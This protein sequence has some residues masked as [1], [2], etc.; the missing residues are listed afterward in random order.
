MHYPCYFGAQY[1]R[2]LTVFTL[3]A[4]TSES[5][6]LR[7][8]TDGSADE[9]NTPPVCHEMQCG[10]DGVFSVMV[11]GDLHGTYYD[12]LLTDRAGFTT[13]SADPWAVAAG[14]NGRRS[15][16]VDL[17][18]TDPAGWEKDHRIGTKGMNPVIWETHVRDFSL[19]AHSGVRPEWRGKYL[20]FTE[21]NT[22]VDSAG[23]HPTCV[24]YLKQLGVTHVQLQPVADY[25]TVDEATGIGYNWGYDIYNYNV[26]EG[27]YSTDPF[28]GEVRIR[29][30]KQLVQALHEEGIGVILDVVYNHTFLR[31]SWLDLTAHGEYYRHDHNGEF[32]NASGCGNET[33]SE[34]EPFRNYMI[35]SVLHWAREYHVDGFRFDLM[36]IHDVQTMNYIRE[37]L[38]KL[39]GGN[40]ILMYG[41]PW[42]CF[43]PAINEP[44][45][46][47]DKGGVKYLDTRIGIFSDATRNA[48]GG[49]TF[50]IKDS[51]YACGKTNAIANIKS[52]VRGHCGTGTLRETRDP[53]QSVQYVSCHDNFTLW[54]RLSVQTGTEFHK[55]GVRTLRRNR[56][57]AGVYLTCAGLG[58]LQSGEE[59]G[60]TKN[61][62]GNSYNGPAMLNALKWGTAHEF[63]KL[64]EWYSGLIRLRQSLFPVFT[65]DVCDRTVFLKVPTDGCV[66]FSRPCREES[67]YETSVVLYNPTVHGQSFHLPEGEWVVL[68]D[69][70]SSQLQGKQPETVRGSYE[71][72]RE[73]VAVLAQRTGG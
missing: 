22:T 70:V 54:D 8:Y 16:V 35:Q 73:S 21:K 44:D 34:R 66:A 53:M 65:E 24:N 10:Q 2:S 56:F 30:L 49:S 72:T 4:P 27:S 33:A 51:G 43:P 5:V 47:V 1:T 13:E 20:A 45:R 62:N 48:I 29:E 19:D 3:W 55:Q 68:A 60:R 71:L 36:A 9:D 28:H 42:S 59:F 7:L 32:L 61:G 25:Y 41:E 69:G 67:G 11:F 14:V 18:K 46:A 40:E 58:F 17:K 38:D 57:A 15:M 31:K 37:E 63:H 52:A 12:Y 26:P 23:R 6:T 64:T 50:D 39:P